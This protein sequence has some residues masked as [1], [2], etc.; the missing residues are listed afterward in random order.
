MMHSDNDRTLD[1][2]KYE[3]SVNRVIT[4][5]LCV[6][7]GFCLGSTIG[8]ATVVTVFFTGSI[9]QFYRNWIRGSYFLNVKLD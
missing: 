7:I 2:R 3:I 9:I 1:K 6:T 4:N 8:I 5:I